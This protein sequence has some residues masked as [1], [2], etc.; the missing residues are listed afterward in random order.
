MILSVCAM[1]VCDGNTPGFCSRAGGIPGG[2]RC[3]CVSVRACV[4]V[5]VC[6]CVCA[7]Y[8][9]VQW[10]GLVLCSEQEGRD[11]GSP[12]EPHHRPF[13]GHCLALAVCNL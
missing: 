9:L 3:V 5:C 6:V 1:W 7:C 8:L 11:Q 2:V 12:Y 10:L 13:Q 4:C